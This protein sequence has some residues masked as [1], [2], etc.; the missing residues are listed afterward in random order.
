MTSEIVCK[1]QCSS[2]FRIG[3]T[4][5]LQDNIEC[6]IFRKIGLLTLPSSSL[7][8]AMKPPKQNCDLSCPN[9]LDIRKRALF[10]CVFCRFIDISWRSERNWRCKRSHWVQNQ[11]GMLISNTLPNSSVMHP[12]REQNGEA[13]VSSYDLLAFF[14]TCLHWSIAKWSVG[15]EHPIRHHWGIHKVL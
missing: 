15:H 9:W 1:W 4:E 2:L 5:R 7:L 13:W 3:T 10:N 11:Q 14:H 8:I 12:E 6:L